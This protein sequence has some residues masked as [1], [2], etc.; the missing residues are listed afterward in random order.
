MHF[1]LTFIATKKNMS[2]NEGEEEITTLSG[3]QRDDD[4]TIAVMKKKNKINKPS[5]RGGIIFPSRRVTRHIR[6]FLR[7]QQRLSADA[8][9]MQTAILNVITADLLD[10]AYQN[11][12]R[13]VKDKSGQTHSVRDHQ[14]ITTRDIYLA[15]CKDDQ[16]SKMYGPSARLVIPNG[17]VWGTKT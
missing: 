5:T 15:L 10:T 12:F 16:W 8:I 3:V 4:N 2:N 14:R 6:P 9:T 1:Q 7:N 13:D 17:G 11:M